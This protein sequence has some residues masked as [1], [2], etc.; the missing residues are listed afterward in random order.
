MR[1]VGRRETPSLADRPLAF[2][3]C[4]SARSDIPRFPSGAEATLR[5]DAGRSQGGVRP[6]SRLVLAGPFFGEAGAGGTAVVLLTAPWHERSVRAVSARYGAAAWIHPRGRGRV[7]DLPELASLPKGV[8]AFVPAGVE[9]A[10]VAFHIPSE[11]ALVVAEFLR[12]TDDGLRV[13]PSP[14]A[15]DLDAFAAS[16]DQLRDLPIDRVLVAHGPSVL[17][18]GGAAI[19]E[20]LD[21]FVRER[22]S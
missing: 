16:L 19:R 2:A 12:G 7:A 8:E 11:R 20:A 4:C 14:A 22:C 10:E 6:R 1:R 9:E 15:K 21:A 17:S 3:S 18:D 13:L 5:A